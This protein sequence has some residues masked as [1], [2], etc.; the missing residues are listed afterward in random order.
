[1]IFREEK[2][3][4][5]AGIRCQFDAPEEAFMVMELCENALRGRSGVVSYRE[6]FNEL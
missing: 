4:D 3:E 5:V 6:E 2:P 1:M